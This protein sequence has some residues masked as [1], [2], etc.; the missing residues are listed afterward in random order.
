MPLAQNQPGDH[1]ATNCWA[2][3]MWPV[4]LLAY[5]RTIQITFFFRPVSP[6][7]SELLCCRL[8]A[9]LAESMEPQDICAE[10]DVLLCRAW[11]FIIFQ[12][13][14]ATCS[15][16][17]KQVGN[18]SAKGSSCLKALHKMLPKQSDHPNHEKDMDFLCGGKNYALVW[19]YLA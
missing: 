19:Y 2:V 12:T 16:R 14:T 4:F 18:H 17:V 5:K 7:T 6:L 13:A 10:G 1:R 8:T 11:E 9:P 3:K 15:R